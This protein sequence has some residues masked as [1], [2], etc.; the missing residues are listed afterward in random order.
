MKLFKFYYNKIM[1]KVSRPRTTNG[2]KE[3][4]NR[5]VDRVVLITGGARGIGQASALRFSAE[6]AFVYILDMLDGN[7]TLNKI[8][9]ENGYDA[10][11]K[12]QYYKLDVTNY[13][14]VSNVVN[15]IYNKRGYIDVLVQC[16]GITGKAGIKAHQVDN[17]DFERVWRINVLGYSIYVK[18]YV[19][20]L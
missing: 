18:L 3:R 8:K 6:G 9:T 7:E 4:L 13:D 14:K 15:Q 17:L 1:S 11:K 2:N 20:H 16:A 5:F 10:Y 12:C 19:I